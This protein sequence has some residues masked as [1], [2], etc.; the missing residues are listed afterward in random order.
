MDALPPISIPPIFAS[1][2]Q[3]ISDLGYYIQKLERVRDKPGQWEVK[4]VVPKGVAIEKP[5]FE[6]GWFG[7]HLHSREIE[8]T[9]KGHIMT[10]KIGE[11]S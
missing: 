4:V 7:H 11:Q 8:P 3:E 6:A 5:S 9:K 1:F 2:A 10:A